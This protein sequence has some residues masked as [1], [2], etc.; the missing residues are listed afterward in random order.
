MPWGEAIDHT[1]SF[2]GV[3]FAEVLKL[4]VVGST[5]FFVPPSLHH[6]PDRP[7]DPSLFLE[8]NVPCVRRVTS[9]SFYNYTR[10]LKCQSVLLLMSAAMNCPSFAV[11]SSA[12]PLKR[13]A[14]EQARDAISSA[15]E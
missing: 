5:E 14:N 8:P 1:G 11:A 4:E 10:W 3:T 6:D 7:R 2:L 9:C 13:A 12:S 15:R